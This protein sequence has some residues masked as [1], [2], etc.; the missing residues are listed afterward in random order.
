MSSSLCEIVLRLTVR[1]VA[2]APSEHSICTNSR[3]AVLCVTSTQPVLVAFLVLVP[4]AG[5]VP[6]GERR[7]SPAAES[8]HCPP[9]SAKAGRLLPKLH[10]NYFTRFQ[11][12]SEVPPVEAAGT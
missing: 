3:S 2:I 11:T 5:T 4:G 10:S 1:P 6:S 9:V 7:H 8:E 12:S